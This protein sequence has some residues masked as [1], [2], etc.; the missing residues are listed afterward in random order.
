MRERYRER[1]GQLEGRW[2]DAEAGR[3]RGLDRRPQLG[4]LPEFPLAAILDGESPWTP[5]ANLAF[6]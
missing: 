2:G 4:F 6:R 3:P 5:K 1:R